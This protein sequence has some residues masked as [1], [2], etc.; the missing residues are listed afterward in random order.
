MCV[1]AYKNFHSHAHTNARSP[2]FCGM[3]ILSLTIIWPPSFYSSGCYFVQK[4]FYMQHTNANAAPKAKK[5]TK[6][7]MAKPQSN[8]A[9]NLGMR[10]LPE[11]VIIFYL[12]LFWKG[13]EE[14]E[15]FKLFYLCLPLADALSIKHII[16]FENELEI[17]LFVKH[18]KR[19]TRLRLLLPFVRCN[20]RDRY[21]INFFFHSLTPRFRLRRLKNE[22]HEGKKTKKHSHGECERQSGTAKEQECTVLP[23]KSSKNWYIDE[24]DDKTNREIKIERAKS[25]EMVC[26]NRRQR[27]RDRERALNEEEEKRKRHNRMRIHLALAN[28]YRKSYK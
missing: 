19:K 11:I 27:Q 26:E 8:K 7:Q 2:K 13:D 22:Q 25:T 5:A 23:Q 6:H 14:E 12:F 16:S 24:K 3:H 15:V 10:L 17:A 1:F 4:I 21:N 20:I 28:I 18:W 9:H